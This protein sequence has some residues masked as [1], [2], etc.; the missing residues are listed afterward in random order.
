MPVAQDLPSKQF[1][2]P[3]CDLINIMGSPILTSNTAAPELPSGQRPDARRR[4]REAVEVLH[5]RNP[6]NPGIHLLC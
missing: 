6:P 3:A 4:Q 1:L 2:S 5:K